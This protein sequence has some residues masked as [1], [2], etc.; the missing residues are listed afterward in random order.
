MVALETGEGEDHAMERKLVCA[1]CGKT[2]ENKETYFA[3]FGHQLH[4]DLPCC[5]QCGQV[6]VDKE[7]AEGKMR[8]TEAELEDK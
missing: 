4:T 7:L 8:N 2:L 3:Y 1:R 5:P 6:Y